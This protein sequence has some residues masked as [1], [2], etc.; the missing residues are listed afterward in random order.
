MDSVSKICGHVYVHED[1][2]GTQPKKQGK[3]RLFDRLFLS[4]S[5]REFTSACRLIK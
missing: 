4:L 1:I 3:N 2:I 5:F